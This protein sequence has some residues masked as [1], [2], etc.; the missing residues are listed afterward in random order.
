MGAV[1]RA[2]GT[3]CGG[4]YRR[5]SRRTDPYLRGLSAVRRLAPKSVPGVRRGAWHGAGEVP[6]SE[7]PLQD[8]LRTEGKRSG[9]NHG[10]RDRNKAWLYRIRPFRSVLPHTFWRTS[11]RDLGC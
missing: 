6:A 7:A 1:L 9:A 2:S 8:P 11:L 4:L 5:S 3:R 10:I